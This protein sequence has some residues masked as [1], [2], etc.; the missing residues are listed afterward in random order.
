ME[1]SVFIYKEMKDIKQVFTLLAL[2]RAKIEK[3]ECLLK[4][5]LLKSVICFV[6]PP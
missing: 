2:H 6:Y 3:I 1:V 5:K 4:S